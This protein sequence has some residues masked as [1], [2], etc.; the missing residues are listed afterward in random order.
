MNH[1]KGNLLEGVNL[2]TGS[3]RNQK[4]FLNQKGAV[5]GN[6]IVSQIHSG[7]YAAEVF[8]RSKN[9]SNLPKNGMITMK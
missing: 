3:P 9:D 5:R 2:P 1:N 6:L 7:A 8:I 4:T